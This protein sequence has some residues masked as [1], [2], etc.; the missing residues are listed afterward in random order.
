MRLLID[1]QSIVWASQYKLPNLKMRAGRKTGGIFGLLR[2]LAF[3]AEKL[4]PEEMVVCWDRRCHKRFELYPDYKNHRQPENLSE[5]DREF[6][7]QVMS[8]IEEA[9]H[10]LRLLPVLQIE[11]EGAEA[12]DTIAVLARFLHLEDVGIFTRD[13]DLYQLVTERCSIINGDAAVEELEFRPREYLIYKVLVGDTSD[14]IN[15]VP[16]V[17]DK[18]TRKLIRE[19]KTLKSIMA[20]AKEAGKLGR[21]TYAEAKAIVR[22][23]VQLMTPGY[24]LTDDQRRHVLD[25]YRN[26]RLER[27]IAAKREIREA[28]RYYSFAS[29]ISRL[30]MFTVGFRSQVRVKDGHKPTPKK[31]Q[32]PAHHKTRST[33]AIHS[34]DREAMR[35]TARIVRKTVPHSRQ[36]ARDRRRRF[37][38]IVRRTVSDADEADPAA[39]L[40]AESQ[41]ID[42][43]LP[44]RVPNADGNTRAQRQQAKALGESRASRVSAGRDRK[45][46]TAGKGATDRATPKE[47]ERRLR[48]IWR[49][50]LLAQ[51]SGW[52]ESQS[53]RVL[54]FVSSMIDRFQRDPLYVP[55]SRD[56]AWIAEIH[57]EYTWQMPEWMGSNPD[58]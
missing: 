32:P 14:H 46:G 31:W 22:R 35:R 30:S 19:Y 38:R 39:V 53:E 36:Y 13:K 41:P 57:D 12:D 26:S 28:F 23:N 17:G 16:G 18:T 11:E 55:N 21:A 15:G 49:L 20:M 25:T 6:R 58:A 27:T 10:L 24:L 37:A 34:Q 5:D 52:I 50:K 8:Q 47:R 43:E 51:D 33:R 56:A 40:A 2:T 1:A 42:R 48:T 4:E 7:E 45:T 29:L 44:A 54:K 9:K 3:L